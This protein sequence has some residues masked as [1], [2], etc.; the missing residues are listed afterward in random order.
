MRTSM[1]HVGLAVAVIGIACSGPDATTDPV[2]EWESEMLGANEV[3]AVSSSARGTAT[4]SVS[5]TTLT[6]S[7]SIATL[8][9]TAITAVGIHQA[10]VGSSQA[11]VAIPLCGSGSAPACTVLAAPGVVTSGTA[12]VTEAQINSMRG[13]GMYVNVKTTQFSTGEIRGQLRNVAP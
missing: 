6:Y 5:G 3:P 2:T 9:T 8:P 13:F 7:V 11:T 4:F 10:N 1:L 12:T